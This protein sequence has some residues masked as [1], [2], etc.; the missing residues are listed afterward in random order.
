MIEIDK[1]TDI[2]SVMLAM[3]NQEVKHP[4]PYL[5]KS[6]LEGV[7]DRGLKGIHKSICLHILYTLGDVYGLL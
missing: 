2:I 3:C 5:R 6:I 4:H 1:S 7:L